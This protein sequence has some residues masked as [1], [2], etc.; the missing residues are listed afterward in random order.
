M[1]TSVHICMLR[2]NRQAETHN[3]TERK[4]Q[5]S[6]SSEAADWSFANWGNNANQLVNSQSVSVSCP[7]SIWVWQLADKWSPFLVG[8]SETTPSCLPCIWMEK[9]GCQVQWHFSIIAKNTLKLCVCVCRT[10]FYWVEFTSPMRWTRVSGKSSFERDGGGW[11]TMTIWENIKR[12]SGKI[13]VVPASPLYI[14]H[15]TSQQQE[16]NTHTHT[17]TH[18][19]MH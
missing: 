12:L 18:T 9:G 17:R 10:V 13:P 4:R 15:W 6:K 1:H 14:T 3:M 2:G 7:V 19:Y 5:E 11:W 8:L 16:T